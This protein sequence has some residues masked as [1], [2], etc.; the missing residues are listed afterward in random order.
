VS[1]QQK[2]EERIACLEANYPASEALFSSVGHW[3][4]YTHLSW[5]SYIRWLWEFEKGE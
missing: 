5:E 3:E 4:N 1:T 2:I